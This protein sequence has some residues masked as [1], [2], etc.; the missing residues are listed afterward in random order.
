LKSTHDVE[1]QGDDAS[2]TAS[3]TARPSPKKASAAT[4]TKGR[5]C[6]DL[7]RRIAPGLP[8]GRPAVGGRSAIAWRGPMARRSPPQGSLEGALAWVAET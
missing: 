3:S 1:A 8:S 6:Y 7:E 2:R 5:R 4:L